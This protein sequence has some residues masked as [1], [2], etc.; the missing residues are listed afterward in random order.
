MRAFR[1]AWAMTAGTSPL[2]RVRKHPVRNPVMAV[3]DR[4]DGVTR[5]KT[6]GP[7]TGGPARRNRPS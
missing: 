2:D 7:A 3:A 4:F 6:A 5:A 1:E